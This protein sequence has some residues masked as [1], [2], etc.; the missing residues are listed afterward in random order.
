MKVSWFYIGHSNASENA[1]VTRFCIDVFCIG[2]SYASGNTKVIRFLVNVV[3]DVFILREFKLKHEEPKG[4]FF[5][6]PHGTSV[7]GDAKN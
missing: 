7:A 6:C 5:A 2:P 3:L 4:C 1:K